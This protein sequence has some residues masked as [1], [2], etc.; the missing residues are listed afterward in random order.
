VLQTTKIRT[1][2]SHDLGIESSAAQ[3][4][5][6][7]YGST[8]PWIAEIPDFGAHIEQGL[9]GF[10]GEFEV[11]DLMGDHQFDRTLMI[12]KMSGDTGLSQRAI[13]RWLSQKEVELHHAGGTIIQIVPKKIHGLRYSGSAR[14]LR[15]R[16]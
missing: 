3:K 12:Q 7:P 11:P 8:I 6:L 9:G 10:P 5:G 13:K 4:M 1:R 16:K 2:L 14:Q 15:K